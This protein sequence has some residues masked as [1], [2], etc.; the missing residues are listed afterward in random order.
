MRKLMLLMVFVV[1][2]CANADENAVAQDKRRCEAYGLR[3]DQVPVCVMQR[4]MQRDRFTQQRL[5]GE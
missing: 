3:P 4:D 5:A 2:A 1:G